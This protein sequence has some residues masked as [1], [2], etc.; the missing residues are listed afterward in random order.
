MHLLT[1]QPG[2]FTDDAGI[3]DLAQ[4]SA[5]LVML[6]AA[7]SVLSL[8]AS[9]I[10]S[11]DDASRPSVRLANWM[12]LLKP[13]AFDL[14]RDRVLDARSDEAPQGPKVVLLSL[15]G[16][17]TYWPY[18][19]EQ[20][21]AWAARPGRTLIVVPGEDMEDEALLN[22]G[23][24]AYEDARRVWRYLREGGLENA[25][26]LLGWL[27]ERFLDRPQPWR[28][29]R[30][31][32][33]VGLYLPGGHS[34]ATIDDWRARWQP[35]RPVAAL[36]FYR[37]HLQQ[38]NTAVFDALIEEIESGGFNPLPVMVAS[39]KEP[40]CLDTLDAL[41]E[42]SDASVM[43]NTTGF[44][45]AG[46]ASGAPSSTLS[47]YRH[48]WTRRIPILQLIM[49]GTSQAAWQ[50]HPKGLRP[51]DIAMHI[52][53]PE[54]DGR[55]ITRPV[56]F[57]SAQRYATRCQHQVVV[58]QL[59]RERSRFV[60]ELARRWAALATGANAD[61]R[62]ALVLANYPASD[63]RIGNGVGLD[64]P[65]STLAILHRLRTEGY[66]VGDVLP[67][68]P[69]A[70]VEWLTET[71]T[72]DADSRRRGAAQSL[73]LATY[74]QLFARLPAASRQA[75]IARWGEPEQDPMQRHGRLMIAGMRLGDTFIGVQPARGFGIDQAAAYHDPDLPP[76]HGYLAFYFWLRHVYRVDAFVHV[77][78][79]G[80]LEW[81]PGKGTAL[82]GECW[83]DIALGPMPHLYPFIVN[84]PGEG[85]QAKR[86]AQAVIVDHLMPPMS[87]AGIHGD[88]AEL[89]RLT[90]EYYQAEG[91][92]E[93]RAQ[94]LIE[95]ILERVKNSHVLEELR[96]TPSARSRGEHSSTGQRS[97]SSAQAIIDD[98]QQL[99][100]AL[101]NYL[102]D[103]KEAQIRDGLH[104]LGQLPQG[105]SLRDTLIS[106]VRLPRGDSPEA[107]GLIHAL[108]ADFDLFAED[109][110]FDPLASDAAPW[111]G[112]RPQA[113][114]ALDDRAWRTR[115]HTRERLEQLAC[116]LVET[117]V[118]NAGPYRTVSGPRQ[119]GFDSLPAPF[120]PPGE[121]AGIP[122]APAADLCKGAINPS[123]G[124][125]FA[126]PG[127]RP[128]R[129]PASGSVTTGFLPCTLERTAPLLAFMRDSLLPLL[130]E[131]V[132]NELA[133]LIE[134]LNGGFVPPG[135]SG[136]P[137]RGR[138]D[139][140]PTGRNFYTL[141]SRAMPTATAWTLGQKAAEALVMRHLQEH[142]DY[143]RSI[144]LSV[145]G[146]ATMRTG[147]DDIAQAFALMG[148][149]PIRTAGTQRLADF[150]V[151]P[152]FQLGR[153]RV[154]VTLRISGFF[155]DAFPGL[156]DLFDCAVRAV[157]EFD[158]PGDANTIAANVTARREAL[159]RDGL[160]ADSAARQAGFRIFGPRPGAYGTGLKALLDGG[161]WED[162]SDL[163]EVWINHG[164]Y[165]WGKG[166][167]G[168]PATDALR[169]RLGTLQA[170]LQNQDNREHDLLDSG[171]YSHFLGG[172]STAARAGG[173]SP[174]LYFGDNANPASPAVRSLKEEI[175]R[176]MR[177]RV[178]NPKWIAAM[179]RHGYKGAFEMAASVDYL[180]SWDATTGQ[181]A[182]YQYQQISD[183]LL[184]N[185]D[186]RRFLDDHN[187]RAL[188][189]MG[190]RLMEAIERGMWQAPGEYERRL[191]SLLLEMD[192]RREMAAP[193]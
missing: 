177:A 183:A 185:D 150:E 24:V 58:Y 3:I 25:R 167:E 63:A 6:S 57:K 49:A 191:Q 98:D 84:D 158:E 13:A 31:L 53:L 20:L 148:V 171:D 109:R 105:E 80:N 68:D 18:G 122:A 101:D 56:A 126:I 29:P 40:L 69:T 64:T 99:L 30:V 124:A 113:L 44:A 120:S 141:D 95:A 39:L 90:D 97:D 184:F 142:G 61:K 165:A 43:L 129:Q 8:F 74:R 93:R 108:A 11:E 133:M 145:W 170:V 16:G 46:G 66:P 169:G 156:I 147:G 79:H 7:D 89:E 190:E 37:S 116:R 131:S 91:L 104:V 19:L 35:E 180:Y 168:E 181:V 14:Y 106:L 87:R 152:A 157:A 70:L 22:A 55:I 143:P 163:A 187:P 48:P 32:P 72:N 179:Q 82:S 182:D 146:T 12:N 114:A 117:H 23:T 21:Q 85:A 110:D 128:L 41:I 88:L 144:G 121:R 173:A 154:D 33:R 100:Q 92:D 34:P 123:M 130:H 2:G 28:E 178:T 76:T 138:L 153:P 75:V 17:A 45:L 27:G 139:T 118:I 4:T 189:E 10:E 112:P 36:V 135:A 174:A 1:A 192:E 94:W 103:I 186:N 149:R 162:E 62:V 107:Q 67:D 51:R 172:M 42:R 111:P 137:S 166:V 161:R 134:G 193:G 160:D 50:D 15:L 81:L 83:P 119:D 176:V 71:V 78:K 73:S 151:I 159:V 47:R 188:Q 115:A 54:I 164:S 26:S 155:R 5:E 52:A 127:E 136:A 96:Q 38:G 60:I 86:R 132:D 175:N 140:L 77:G 125:T 65:A 102:C 9:V 59:H